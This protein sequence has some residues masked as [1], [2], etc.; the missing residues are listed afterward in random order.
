MA[1]TGVHYALWSPSASLSQHVDGE[2]QLLEGGGTAYEEPFLETVADVRS[3]LSS[4]GKF[5]LVE[6]Y[7]DYG[8]S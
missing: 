6:V 3:V 1:C 4:G 7:A 8:F 5:T 2:S